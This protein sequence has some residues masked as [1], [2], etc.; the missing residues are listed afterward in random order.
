MR[1]V[2][3]AL[4]EKIAMQSSSTSMHFCALDLGAESGRVMHGEFDG[5]RLELSEIH[6]FESRPVQVPDGL[7]TDALHIWSELKNGM[8]TAA[9]K[10][11]GV[12]AGIGVDTWGVDFAFLDK[13]GSLL[14]NPYHYRDTLTDGILPKAFKKVSRPDIFEQT[15]LQFMPINTLYQL[16]ALKL[17]ES[18][19]LNHA[20]ALL[21]MPDLFNYWLTGHVV[22]EFTI[23]TTSQCFDPRKKT[24]A[25]PLLKRFGLPTNLFRPVVEP[26]S[27]L[28]KLLPQVRD[29]IG[30]GEDVSVIAPGCHDTACAVA[31]VPATNKSFAFISCGTWSVLGAEINKPCIT[32]ASLAADFTNE[33]GVAGTY[34][35]LK[36]LTGLW[37][38]QE[39]RREWEKQ[40]EDLSYSELTE[41]AAETEPLM[42][43]IDPAS[44]EFGKP[45]DM[46]T[47]IRAF[48]KKTGQKI[49]ES[50]GAVVRCAL[51]SLALSYRSTLEK[52]E[53]ILNYRLDP[54]HIVGGGTQNRLLCQFAANATE[55]T[56]VAGPVEAAA[57][58]NV[59]MQAIA[60]GHI[61][62][63][64]EA[65][66]IVRSSF[67]TATYT[68]EN[69]RQWDEAYER[70]EVL[71]S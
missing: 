40:G 53:A 57:I 1:H 22:N 41:L 10:V 70:F 19:L 67:E 46:P 3:A 39:C 51:E 32:P 28:G 66:N 5:K 24:W 20:D 44:P 60:L 65:R 4:R 15:G 12:I 26:G 33:G 31:A 14:T 62:S 50:K 21:M 55:R 9:R 36:N 47:R 64:D 54:I 17:R 29:E 45:G 59:V 58:G 27:V 30:C 63:V 61:A 43:I 8:A 38:V 11:N 49:P 13:K 52:I 6:R 68:P 25:L 7:Y 35:F 18:P 48:C 69:H 56:V 23:A 37:L 34:R 42:T 16:Y 71:Q 2:R